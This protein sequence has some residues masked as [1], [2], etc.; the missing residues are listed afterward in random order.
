MSTLG[1]ML[2]KRAA[3]LGFSDAE[4]ARRAGLSPRRYGFYVTGDR[5]PNYPTLLQICRVLDTSPNHVLGFEVEKGG[6]TA[7]SRQKLESRLNA[8]CNL[9]SDEKL[10]LVADHADL[11]LNWRK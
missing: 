10:K 2:R 7:T 3:E 4:V 8:T 5:E 1:E 11:V 9:L 6:Q